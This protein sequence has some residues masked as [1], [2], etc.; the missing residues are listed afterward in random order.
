MST[1]IQRRGAIREGIR[2]EVFTISWMVIEAAVAIGAGVLSRSVLLTAF[3]LD[4]AIEL[5]SGVTL[6]WGLAAEAR[7]AELERIDRVERRAVQMSAVLLVLVC[8]YLLA[9]SAGALLFRLE[10]GGS[11]AGLAIS[12]AAVVVMPLLAR[13]KREVNKRIGSP[14]LRADI[15][16]TITW[17]YMA[18]AA[19]LGVALST[20]LGWWWAE[21][22]AALGL[23]LF[24]GREAWEALESARESG[25]R[26]EDDD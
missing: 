16:E 17:A 5:I 25:G 9:T 15:A 10:P 18:G 19:L 3:G 2:L 24:I 22:L 23:L 7:N 11:W 1:E 12:A 6:L 20:L 21:Y 26:A 4:S 13:R 8:V 14:A